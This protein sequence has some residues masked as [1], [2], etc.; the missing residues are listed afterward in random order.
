MRS[1][2]LTLCLCAAASAA[3]APPFSRAI[4]YSQPGDEHAAREARRYIFL[5]TG[6][7]SA[8]HLSTNSSSRTLRGWL[9]GADGASEQREAIVITSPEALLAELGSRAAASSSSSSAAAAELVGDAHTVTR[10]GNAVLLLG[11]TTEGRL[12]AA[13]TLA[14]RLGVRFDS[15]A[16]LLPDPTAPGGL[17]LARCASSPLPVDSAATATSSTPTFAYRGLQPFHDFVEGPDWWNEDAYKHVIDQIAKMKMNFIGLHTYP[18]HAHA[19]TRTGTNEP[20]VWV[21][22]K[23]ELAEDGTILVD[24][25]GAYPTSYANTLRGEWA[26]AALAT[27]NYSWGTAELFE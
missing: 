12:Y 21:G 3:A 10:T 4:F 18:Y 1:R 16:D 14:E 2:V 20:T 8:L 26:E 7:W 27:S 15:H 9:D 17:P 22:V 24:G 23:E 19:P 13:Y 6:G 5:T 25:G 11:G